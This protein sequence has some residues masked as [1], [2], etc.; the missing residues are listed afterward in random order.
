MNYAGRLFIDNKDAF[1]EY[2]VFVER[3][4]YKA[5]IQM[6]PFKTPESTEWEEYDGAEFDLTDPVLDSKTFQMQF[7]VMNVSQV[8]DL[9]YVLS[10][11]SYHIFNFVELGR[12][13]KL[14]LSQNQNISS[15]VSLGKMTVS[16]VDDFPPI[17]YQSGMTQ[18]DLSAE[19]PSVLNV[20]P[21]E[22]SVTKDEVA[23][24]IDDIPF[25]RFGV[26]ALDGTIQNVLKNP[27]VR[28]NLKVNIK[29]KAGID[30]DDE[31]V[32]YKTKDVQMKLLIH[33]NTIS[34]FWH[35][36]DSLFT[37]LIQPETREL[38][39]WDVINA[40]ECF[41]K[42]NQVTKFDILRNGHVWCEFTLTLTFVSDR[43]EETE[44]LLATEDMVWIVTEDEDDND[45]VKLDK[46]T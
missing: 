14:R 13:Y 18:E 31:E 3:Y 15:R 2:G 44:W 40:Y 17:R 22:T 41:Y 16:F 26:L 29:G 36:W 5:L 9:F 1:T 27:N 28:D 20:D 35:R 45:F 39:A 30:Y 8:S 38:F 34:D 33:A 21:Y 46:N 10:D 32:L 19:Y 24:S 12:S 6:P 23:F 37:A 11:K 42:N 43:P 7:C 4:G 25:D